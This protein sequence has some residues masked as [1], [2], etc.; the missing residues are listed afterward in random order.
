MPRPKAHIFPRTTGFE[1]T[2]TCGHTYKDRVRLP[3]EHSG[4]ERTPERE[5]AVVKFLETTVTERSAAN[6]PSCQAEVETVAAAGWVQSA[7]QIFDLKPLP[8]LTGSPRQ[9][10]VAQWLQYQRLQN[11][12]WSAQRSVLSLM[13]A[14]VLTV[15]MLSALKNSH[16][17]S[18]DDVQ[19]TGDI[20]AMAFLAGSG[21][22]P[23]LPVSGSLAEI[24]GPIA[25]GTEISKHARGEITFGLATWLVTRYLAERTNLHS[26]SASAETWVK[27]Y[28]A[29]RA[30]PIFLRNDLLNPIVDVPLDVVVAA[31]AVA[32]QHGWKDRFEAEEAFIAGCQGVSRDMEPF[33]ESLHGTPL[34]ESLEQAAVYSALQPDNGWGHHDYTP[35]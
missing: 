6:C 27:A 24:Y 28:F 9:I 25:H 19:I 3:Y 23:S 4:K 33:L 16:T 15:L 8:A 14:N 30:R 17:V 13:R 7:L 5:A 12:R 26:A 18:Q 10:A 20:H 29:N 2:G 1:A 31:V 35:F 11:L 21:N 34:N 32:S 22:M